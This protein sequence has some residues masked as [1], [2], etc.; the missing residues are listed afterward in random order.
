MPGVNALRT[1]V[2]LVGPALVAVG[3]VALTDGPV[4]LVAGAVA[5]GEPGGRAA[6]GS[7]LDAGDGA[8]EAPRVGLEIDLV[9]IPGPA[10]RWAGLGRPG[11]FVSRFEITNAQYLEFV[12]ATGYDGSEHP[13]SKS[14]EPFLGHVVDGSCPADQLDHPVCNLN[15]H[16]A[17]AFCAWLSERSGVV[18]RL[19]TDAEWM[20]IAAGADGRM[21]PWGDPW[22]PTLCNWGDNTGGDRFG[23]V[24]GVR[25]S[26]AVGTFPAGATPEGVEDMAGNIWEWSAEGHLRGGPWCLGPEMMRC[27]VVADEGVDQANDKFGFRVVVEPARSAEF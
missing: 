25:E 20:W 3:V 10:R 15:W 13:S 22:D 6:G 23:L 19:P 17:V 2:L 18:V 5:S 16:H 27:E 14:S 12:R 26:A 4:V 1:T 8:P 21:Y 9:W 11:V 24:D 7:G